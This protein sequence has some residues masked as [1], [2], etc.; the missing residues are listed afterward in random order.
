MHC[1]TSLVLVL[2][3]AL[4]VGADEPEPGRT[5]GPEGSE[6]GK[7]GYRYFRMDGKFFVEGYFGAAGVDIEDDD[8]G[9]DFSETDL[10]AGFNAGYMIEDWV[11]FQLGYG[12]ITDQKINLFSAGMRSSYNMEPFNYYFSLNAE[13]FAPDQG[14]ERFGIVPGVGAELI[15]SDH[16]RV[17]LQYQHD[18]IFADETISVNRVTAKVQFDF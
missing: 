13:L 9:V 6:Y 4:A 3:L 17:G 1:V 18:F 8:A 12:Y 10:I 16:L 5:D 15:M 7:G 11:G 14:D 2:A